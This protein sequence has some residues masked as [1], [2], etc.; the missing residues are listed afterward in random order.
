MTDD[1]LVS[2]YRKGMTVVVS[3]SCVVSFEVNNHGCHDWKRL[4]AHISLRS[5]TEMTTVTKTMI[6]PEID[7]LQNKDLRFLSFKP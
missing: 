1:V 3:H 7:L 4:N 6:L 5:Q 2:L